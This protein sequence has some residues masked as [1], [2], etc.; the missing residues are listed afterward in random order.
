MVIAA[1]SSQESNSGGSSSGSKESGGLVQG[2]TDEKILIGHLGPQTGPAAIYDLVRKGIDSHFKYVNE[3]GGVNG[4]KL[5]LVAYDDQYQPAKAVQLAKRLVEEDKVFAVLGSVCTPCNTA[6]K[7]YYVQ[8]GI[9]I[10]LVNSGAKEFVDPPMDNYWGSAIFNYRA[11]AKIFLDYAINKLGAKKIGLA[12]QNDDFGKEGYEGVKEAI[13]D[14]PEAEIVVETPFLATDTEFSSQAQKLQEAN[15]DVILN[16][17]TPNPAANLKKAMY[18]IG[19]NEAD[20]IVATVGA[21]DINLFE[22]AGKDVWEGTYSGA[23][24]PMPEAAQDDEDIQLYVERFSKDFPNEPTSGFAQNGWA[25]AQVLVESLMRTEGELTWENY[26]KTFPTFD[27]WDESIY[28]GIT[29]SEDNHYGL[30]SMFMTQAKDGKIEP[31][32]EPISFD[33]VTGEIK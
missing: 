2:V 28:A 9:P 25:V 19:F 10:V 29:F 21:N 26:L 22:L 16:F 14:Y 32:T 23:V 7:D 8:K 31:I 11:E 6:A 33:P 13:K 1:C 17:A 3:N 24:Y 18:K 12:Y 30:T 5:E 15:P 4:K 27:N 20:Y